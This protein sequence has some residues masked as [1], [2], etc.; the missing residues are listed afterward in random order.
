MDRTGKARENRSGDGGGGNLRYRGGETD[1]L[2]EA[3]SLDL[4]TRRLM[5][6]LR[7]AQFQQGDAQVKADARRAV[8]DNLQKLVHDMRNKKGTTT[9]FAGADRK[10]EAQVTDAMNAQ[11]VFDRTTVKRVTDLARVLIEQGYLPDLRDSEVKKLL[12]AARDATAMED[13]GAQVEKIVDVM[14]DNQVRQS[15]WELGEAMKERGSRTDSRGVEVQGSLD[16]QGV[17]LMDAMKEGLDMREADLDDRIWD[18][19]NRLSDPDPDVSADAALELTGLELAREYAERITDSKADEARMRQDLKDAKADLKAGR[20]TRDAYNSIEDALREQMRKERIKRAQAAYDLAERVGGHVT[21]SQERAKAFREAQAEHVREIQHNANSDMEGRPAM[22]HRKDSRLGKLMNSWAAQVLLAPLGTFDQMLRVFGNKSA[23]GEGYLWNRFMRGWEESR[24]KELR[25]V[26]AKHAA[27][28]AKAAELFGKGKSW[29][30]LILGDGKLPKLEVEFMDGGEMRPHEL[31]QGNL[32]YIYMVDKMT[33]GMVK[34]RRMG[35]DEAAM[36]RIK[37]ALD[38]RYRALADWLQEEFLP[39]ARK[40]YNATHERM[41]GASMAEIENYFPLKILAN[42]R[43]DTED[44]LNGQGG[45]GGIMTKTGAIVKR[46]HNSLALDV[47]GANALSVI[48]DHVAE[49]EHWNAY[50]EWNRDLNVLRTYKRFR[51]QVQNMTTAYGAGKKLWDKFNDLC[52]V[53]AGQYK[54]KRGAAETGA[55]NFA[56]GVTA[57]KVSFR[58]FTALKQLL[59]AP[60]YIPEVSAAAIAKSVANPYAAFKWSM[61]NL[62]IFRER[63]RSRISGNPQLLKTEKDWSIWRNRVVEMAARVGMTPNAFVD[64]VTVAIGAKAIYET[65]LKQYLKEGYPADMAEKRA[66]QDA[67]ILFNQTQQSSESPF[68]SMMQVDHSWYNT[69]MSIFRNASMSYTRQTFDAARNL[70]R[71][72]L[73]PGQRS[74]SVAFMAKQILRDWGVD[75]DGATADE[76]AKAEKAASAR[77]NRQIRKDLL[78]VGTFGYLLEWLWNLGPYAAYLIFGA[79]DDEKRKMWKDAAVHALFGP[80][81]GLTGGDAMSNMANA[82]VSGE[83]ED[84]DKYVKNMPLSEDFLT[85]GRKFKA[86]KYGEATTDIVYAV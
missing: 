84:F 31:T 43:V 86:S 26:E 82:A 68:L 63:W 16:I 3:G 20:I 4:D 17:K 57:A 85:I 81:E 28:D 80:I 51:N 60:A 36:D 34:L 9:K 33:D 27:L 69:L 10:V 78:R 55:V 64:A 45:Q 46:R 62:P 8:I 53:V 7:L 59:S 15:E 65:R 52:L 32:M 19:Q 2:W 70:N 75:P 23:S 47:T 76:R 44:D 42:A 11:A 35:I 83:L 38:P 48:L 40:E 29:G 50:A 54:P 37:A 67:T 14:V 61:E 13:I 39:Q 41:F 74:K 73:T 21:E 1:D 25:G 56:K 12:A 18:A 30:D 66:K 49:M 24:E 71:N 6:Q 5:A 58:V 22:E 79:N 72:L 77:Y